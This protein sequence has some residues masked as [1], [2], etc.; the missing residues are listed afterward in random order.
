LHKSSYSQVY[1]QI[2]GGNARSS[3]ARAGDASIS[4]SHPEGCK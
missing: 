3:V 4:L 2:S 1:I